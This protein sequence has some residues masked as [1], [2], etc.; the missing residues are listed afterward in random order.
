M[1]TA[2]ALNLILGWT[3]YQNSLGVGNFIIQGNLISEAAEI[4]VNAVTVSL[5]KDGL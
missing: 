3:V 5:Y 2:L 4:P 1:I